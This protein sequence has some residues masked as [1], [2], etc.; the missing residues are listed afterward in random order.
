MFEPFEGAKLKLAR[1]GVYLEQLEKKIHYHEHNAET[2]F[3]HTG[4]TENG[5]RLRVVTEVPKVIPILVGDIAHQLRSSL[6]VAMGDVARIRGVGLK[7]MTFPIVLNEAKFLEKLQLPNK[8]VPWK[9]LGEDVVNYIQA[10]APYHGGNQALRDL[11]D[12]NNQDK[13]KMVVPASEFVSTR[14]DPAADLSH[15]TGLNIMSISVSGGAPG[16]LYAYKP[17]QKIFDKDFFKHP[18]DCLSVNPQATRVIF[19]ENSVAAGK[20]I[21][22]CMNSISKE[23]E[24]VINTLEQ[25]A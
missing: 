17:N 2:E 3:Y 5:W 13:H 15:R 1:A 12:I 11:H 4:E 23:A 16:I 25:M 6:D 21:Y 20:G 14:R 9:K 19:A 10:L 24:K 18:S 7:D 8:K 22:D